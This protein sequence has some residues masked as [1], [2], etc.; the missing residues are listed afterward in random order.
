L[1][2][3]IECEECSIFS[4]GYAATGTLAR[5]VIDGAKEIKIYGKKIPVHARIHTINGFSAHA[6]H[7]ELLAWHR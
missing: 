2:H 6:D 3:N 1:Q 5:H 7:D 4:I